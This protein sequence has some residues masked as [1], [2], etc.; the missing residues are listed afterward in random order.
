MFK[1]ATTD[2][3]SY[4]ATPSKRDFVKELADALPKWWYPLGTLLLNHRLALPTGLSLFPATTAIFVTPQHQE[5]S[6]A[7]VTEL[8]TN[9][10]PISELW[11]DMGS[12]TPEQK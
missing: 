9:Y 12:N 11:F 3:N 1:T 8:L 2:Y 4:D 6:K 5:F 10:G 7:Q